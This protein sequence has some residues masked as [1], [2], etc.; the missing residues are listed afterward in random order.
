MTSKGLIDELHFRYNRNRD[1]RVSSFELKKLVSDYVMYPRI[2]ELA[3]IC[4]PTQ[5]LKAAD[6][7]NNGF[8]SKEE[9]SQSFG[10]LQQYL[11]SYLQA[12]EREGDRKGGGGRGGGG[13]SSERER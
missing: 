13:E 9:F 2:K 3:E 8:L 4:H 5:W 10:K 6:K 11:T 1:Q 12:F 7:D